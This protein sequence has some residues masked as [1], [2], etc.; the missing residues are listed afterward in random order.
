MDISGL[1]LSKD[2]Y[3][4]S[5]TDYGGGVKI[6]NFSN[7]GIQSQMQVQSNI[8]NQAVIPNEDENIKTDNNSNN[9]SG[10]ISFTVFVRN[11]HRYLAL[12][13]SYL[14][15]KAAVPNNPTLL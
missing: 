10:N 13:D 12:E 15:L 11:S 14:S 8:T 9:T 5:V 3:F 4:L 7:I 1:K 6:F 2:G